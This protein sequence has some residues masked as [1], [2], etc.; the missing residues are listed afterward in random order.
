MSKVQAA[1]RVLAA[2]AIAAYFL[3]FAWGGLQAGFTN[4]DL[5]N[6]YRA[7]APPVSQHLWDTVLFW[8]F[9]DSY[10]PV[11]SLFYRLLLESF[12]L[13]PLPFRIACYALMLLNLWLAYAA[14]RRV[15][16]S[17]ETAALAVLL[18]AYHGQFWAFFINTGLCYDLLCFAFYTGAMLYYLRARERRFPLAWR[19]V[20]VWAGLY[21]LCLNSK[22]MAV[23]LPVVLLVYE[24]LDKPPEW[25]HLPAWLWRHARV[26][27]AGAA[28][29][30][31]FI[32]GRVTAPQGL[33]VMGAY[34]PEVSPAVYLERA[35]HFLAL[36]LYMPELSSAAGAAFLVLLLVVAVLWRSLPF[37]L[38]LAWVLVGIL[39]VAF[40]PQRGLDA[41][42]VVLPGLALS[43]AA[44]VS[45]LA[46][47]A[48]L[49]PAVVFVA[50]FA[51][52]LFVHHRYGRMDFPPR[53]A[54]GRRIAA[55][56][57]QIRELQKVPFAP[58]SRILI[59][60]DP[61]QVHGVWNSVFLVY[62]TSRE[63]TLQVNRASHLDETHFSGPLDFD[64]VFAWKNDRLVECGG[65][66][67]RQLR[68]S[69]LPSFPCAATGDQ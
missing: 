11:G 57:E 25:R 29:T 40:I 35:R 12:G 47:L 5:M 9:S 24:L 44:A 22:E 38:G 14:L 16:A 6:L 62:L 68:V 4:D 31:L 48:R 39:P 27:A 23:S 55:V 66:P 10:R 49:R 37:R 67:F 15:A 26:P 34:S 59:L 52:A 60:S 65:G 18:L 41:I 64:R 69:D 1:L 58:H 19:D 63:R 56:Q 51:A 43:I 7:W 53:L 8:R 17:R 45:A 13:N 42:Y 20:A 33:A 54:E 3:A 30:A 61:F 46:R 21:L 36:I 2:T 32:A 50:L 28:M